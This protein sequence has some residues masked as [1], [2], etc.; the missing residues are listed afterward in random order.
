MI[1]VEKF[2]QVDSFFRVD[3]NRLLMSC[4]SQTRAMEIHAFQTAIKTA[5]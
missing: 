2:A 4:H 3:K 5:A 1:S